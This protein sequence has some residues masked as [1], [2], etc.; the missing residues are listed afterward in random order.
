[1]LRPVTVPSLGNRAA[2]E[3][4]A[5]K[6]GFCRRERSPAG[7]LPESPATFSFAALPCLRALCGAGSGRH[8]GPRCTQNGVRAKSELGV[9]AR[10]CSQEGPESALQG[11]W[12]GHPAVFQQ[13][14]P[15]VRCGCPGVA[16][17]Q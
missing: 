9:E 12:A 8:G 17:V 7:S 11:L 15:A 16:A 3:R 2:W 10:E 1:M 6:G 4:R 5:R 14:Q 13:K